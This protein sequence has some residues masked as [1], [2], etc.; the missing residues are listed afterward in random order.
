MWVPNS[1]S[2]SGLRS[3]SAKIGF[4]EFSTDSSR[5]ATDGEGGQLDVVGVVARGQRL[6]GGGLQG[7]ARVVAEGVGIGDALPVGAQPHDGGKHLLVDERQVFRPAGM[8][9]KGS[10]LAIQHH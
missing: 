5:K 8:R 9:R 7:F 4:C 1:S 3:Q 10:W 2:C 6:V